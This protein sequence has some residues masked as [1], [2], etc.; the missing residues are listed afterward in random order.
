MTIYGKKLENLLQYQ[1][2]KSVL[3]AT[4]NLSRLYQVHKLYNVYM[5]ILF[6]AYLFSI[7]TTSVNI[8]VTI[9]VTEGNRKTQ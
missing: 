7:A 5:Q 9:Y 8:Y 6:E 4:F 1:E 3:H 2:W